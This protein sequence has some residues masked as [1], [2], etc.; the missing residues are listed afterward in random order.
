MSLSLG[1]IIQIS[2]PNNSD[3]NDKIFLITYISNDTIKLIDETTL[4]EIVLNVKNG[5]LSDETITEISIIDRASNPSYARQNKL[6]PGT[7]VDIYF[8]G[9]IPFVVTGEI[10][11]LE[12]DMIEVTTFPE[13]DVIYIDFGYTGIP[14]DLPIEKILIREPVDAAVKDIETKPEL[15]TEQLEEEEDI[16]IDPN[17][18]LQEVIISADNID[19]GKTLDTITQVVEV[20]EDEKRFS[21]T[22]QVNDLLDELLSRI[23]TVERTPDVVNE[24]HTI[25]TRFKQLREAYSTFDQMGN[26]LPV[27]FRSTDYK[28]L[29]Q[30]LKTL[31]K[32]LYWL[33]P[34]VKN[35]FKLYDVNYYETDDID[36]EPLSLMGDSTTPLGILQQ[37]NTDLENYKNN[38]IPTDKYSYLANTISSYG[39]PFLPPNTLSSVITSL[40]V[41]TNTHV[42]VNNL[43][44]FDSSV[45]RGGSQ[46]SSVKSYRYQIQRYNTGLTKL[47]RDVNKQLVPIELTPSNQAYVNGLVFLPHYYVEYTSASLPATNIMQRSKLN[48]LELNYWQYLQSRLNISVESLDSFAKDYKPTSF[49]SSPVGVSLDDEVG[50][51]ERYDNFLKTVIP[52]NR[53]LFEMSKPY[54]GNPTSYMKAIS[55]LQPYMIYSDDIIFQQY[56]P[57]ANFVKANIDEYKRA[58]AAKRIEFSKFKNRKRYTK[59]NSEITD[60][61]TT[62]EYNSYNLTEQMVSAEML[63]KMLISDYAEMFSTYATFGAQTLYSSTNVKEY[64]Q[65]KLNDTRAEISTQLSNNQCKKYIIAKI[66]NDPFELENDNER[67]IFFDPHLDTTDYDIIKE[68][69]RGMMNEQEYIDYVAAKLMEN[70][71]LPEQQALYDARTMIEGRKKVIDGQYAIIEGFLVDSPEV[72]IYYY[73]RNNNTWVYDREATNINATRDTTMFCDLQEPCIKMKERCVQTP[74]FMETTKASLLDDITSEFAQELSSSKR[75]LLEQLKVRIVEDVFRL[76][77][78]K[79]QETYKT[80]KYDIAKRIIGNEVAG[81]DERVSPY[82]DML[83][84]ILGQPDF[85]TRQTNIIKFSQTY[86]IEGPD[87]FRLCITTGLPLLPTFLLRLANSYFDG[88]YSTT[89]DAICKEQGTISDSGNA[90]VDK[91]SGYFIRSI[92]Y[93]I[94]E[95]YEATGYKIV[96]RDIL[97]EDLGQMV[98]RHTSREAQI[99]TNI[100]N[101][102]TQNMGVPVSSQLEFIITGVMALINRQLPS[103]A[104]YE[105]RTSQAAAKGKRL[106]TY[107]FVFDNLLLLATLS[108]LLVA[109]QTQTPSVR[110][111]VTFPGCLRSFKGYP[112]YDDANMQ[113]LTYIACAANK[114]KSSVSPWN[115]IKKMNEETLVSKIKSIIDKH[116]LS[117]AEVIEKIKI[118]QEFVNTQRDEEF[119]PEEHVITRWSTFLPPLR[120]VNVGPVRSITPEFKTTLID[121]VKSGNKSQDEQL[122]VLHSKVFY[123]SL[124]IIQT[125]QRVI[126]K[127]AVIL[128]NSNQEP[129]LENVCCNLGERETLKYFKDR[130][131]SIQQHNILSE[132][133]MNLYNKVK[134]ATYAQLMLDAVDNTFVYPELEQKFS[135][136]TIYGAFIYYCQYNRGLPI[137]E[138]LRAVCDVNTSD[139]KVSATLQEKIEILKSEGRLYTYEGLLLLLDI[140]GRENMIDLDLD[141]QVINVRERMLG[142]LDYFQTQ[143]ECDSC[144]PLALRNMLTALMDTYDLFY[145]ERNEDVDK[146]RNYLIVE[147]RNMK[148]TIMSYLNE[149]GLFGSLRKRK[150]QTFFDEIGN[151]VLQDGEGLLNGKDMMALQVYEYIRSSLI[152]MNDIFPQIILNEIGYANVPVPSVWKLSDRHKKDVQQLIHKELQP[153]EKFYGQTIIQAVLK[154]IRPETRDIMRLAENIPFL[155]SSERN[156]KVLKSVFNDEVVKELSEFYLLFSFATYIRI[157]NDFAEQVAMVPVPG[158]EQSELLEVEISSGERLGIHQRVAELIETYVEILSK[159]KNTVNL[160]YEEIMNK[161][162]RAKEK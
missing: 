139:Y 37:E 123:Y 16:A 97:E 113:S 159:N 30:V 154:R 135:E 101:T 150:M 25:V 121:N 151:W 93:D 106:P 78:I 67:E 156:N 26:A 125:I 160:N 91:Q 95:G 32:D 51:E 80:N 57:I 148:E 85:V 108:Y 107:T 29:V 42:V 114:L 143:G 55:Y 82:L 13:R 8:E 88:T 142:V 49:L 117:D 112:T 10:T 86:T 15:E 43:G 146:L 31:D 138:S 103:K 64:M 90:W 14:K 35:K 60:I 87:Y 70:V 83:H 4:K 109:I 47:K 111:R 162:L 72:N 61:M 130:E 1:D 110:T 120:A 65:N 137:K 116:L 127:E 28:P 81:R 39:T 149:S 56:V 7:W 46:Q 136:E 118:K 98:T 153:L 48:K 36:F 18:R 158:I 71:G 89:I 124:A 40:P 24:I 129:F 73:V 126:N 92:D 77:R 141:R 17:I 79:A 96:S 38:R 22:T 147:N 21:L 115:T 54:M 5:V 100:V 152:K 62:D 27:K 105:R 59:I 84:T 128:K 74:T 52:T 76:Q 119:I 99:I 33:L 131:S 144:I 20:A 58:F 145:E 94:Q 19:F 102:L 132:T 53:N 104:D 134:N 11:N 122:F 23:P 69:N 68:Y 157:A 155:A 75:K 12:E 140:V 50:G 6:T 2:A 3:L 66:Y 44:D 9:D 41:S 133:L 45:A 63:N 161:V 34:I